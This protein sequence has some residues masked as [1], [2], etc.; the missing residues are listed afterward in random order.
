MSAVKLAGLRPIQT[1]MAPDREAELLKALAAAEQAARAKSQFLATMG[2]EL[3]TPLTAIIGCSEVLVDELEAR[4][5]TLLASDAK[6]IRM[7]GH[8]LLRL[9]N[10]ILDLSKIDAGKME[11]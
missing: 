3:R 8:H 7:A 5:D 4:G 1:G 9:I 11:L 6:Q 2:H 10:D